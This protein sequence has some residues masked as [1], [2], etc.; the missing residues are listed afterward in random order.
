ML[1]LLQKG[2]IILIII[3][4]LYVFGTGLIEAAKIFGF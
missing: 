4:V 1:K 2:L 3:A